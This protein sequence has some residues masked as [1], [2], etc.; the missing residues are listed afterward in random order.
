MASVRGLGYV[1]V[2]AS[3]LD[4]WASFATE[5]LGMQ[6]AESTGD[7]LLLRMDAKQYRIDVRRGDADA[8]S[9]L[10]WETTSQAELD[11][12]AALVESD[13]Y[14]VKAGDAE[15]LRERRV[16]GLFSFEDQDGL[17]VEVFYGLANDHRAFVSPNGARFTTG[18]LGIG[19][20]NQFVTDVEVHRHLYM[21]LLGFTLTGYMDFGP[22]GIFLHCN[23][24]NHSI[25]FAH[26]PGVKP[27]IAHLM[28]EVEDI[29][30]VGRAYDRVLAGAA[31]LRVTL[32]KHSNDLML[33]FYVKSPSEFEI[34]YGWK[35]MQID[36]STY[37]PERWN[38]P[39]LWGHQRL[40][41]APDL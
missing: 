37:T 8:V 3:D 20:V 26:F 38:A 4:A 34:E 11:E 40:G 9:V 21:D 14:V 18:S 23:P 13:G 12:L 27:S 25:A 41:S 39:N 24:R 15:D 5:L 1:V 10:G 29:D 2:T 6:I 36:D 31:P 7:R 19:H 17:T 22:G 16:S 32:G 33:S 28:V 30:T 35:G